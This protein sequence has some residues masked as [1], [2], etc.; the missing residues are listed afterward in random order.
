MNHVLLIISACVKNDDKI[1]G[2]DDPL[3]RGLRLAKAD[4]TSPDT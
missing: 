2:D 1:L 4:R 3:H